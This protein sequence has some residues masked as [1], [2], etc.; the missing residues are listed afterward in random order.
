MLPRPIVSA[1]R[2]AAFVAENVAKLSAR[3]VDH[4]LARAS[5]P[6]QDF[7]NVLLRLS[8]DKHSLISGVIRWRT[9]FQ[10]S[11]AEFWF[12]QTGW[13]LGSRFPDGVEWRPPSSTSNQRALILATFEGI[14]RAA[15]W[16]AD[17][18]VGYKYDTLGI[19]GIATARDWHNKKE[20]FCSETIAESG[21]HRFPA[22]AFILADIPEIVNLPLI[23]KAIPVE[24]VTP[25]DLLISPL[26]KVISREVSL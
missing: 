22:G 20:R 6:T 2:G 3:N 15:K 16:V 23:N 7:S 1:L 13:T 5:M 25:R 9:D 26:V 18:R 14:G 17:N 24:Q 11:H 8:T 21:E 12:P 10:C 4:H 19:F